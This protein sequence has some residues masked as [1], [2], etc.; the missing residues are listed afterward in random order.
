MGFTDYLKALFA[1]AGE[2]TTQPV[3]AVAY[4]G[5]DIQPEPM[6]DNG[7]FRVQGWLTRDGQTHHFIRADLLPN[8]DLCVEETLRKA[9]VLIDQQGSDL[10]R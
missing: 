9:R 10:F 6:A 3:A 7:P 2:K 1:N 8:H 5:F 4:K